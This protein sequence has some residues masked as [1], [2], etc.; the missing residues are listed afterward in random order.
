MLKM[1]VICVVGHFMTD[2]DVINVLVQVTFEMFT[3]TLYSPYEQQR[4]DNPSL[5]HCKG[6][7]NV[8]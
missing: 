1:D 7:R 4:A 3:Q 8:V 6:H 2:C 5:W